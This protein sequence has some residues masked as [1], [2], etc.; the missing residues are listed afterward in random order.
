MADITTIPV[1]ELLDDLAASAMDAIMCERL[2][3]ARFRD[4]I[5]GNREIIAV[6]HAELERRG[7]VVCAFCRRAASQEPCEHCQRFNQ[8][9]D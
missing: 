3:P 9:E 8:E 1:S 7:L 2:G 4:R 6:I 5:D